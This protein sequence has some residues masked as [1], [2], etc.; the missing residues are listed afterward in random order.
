MRIIQIHSDGGVSKLYEK[1]DKVVIKNNVYVGLNHD[2]ILLRGTL[3]T[4]VECVVNYP[5]DFKGINRKPY[6]AEI[7]G[8]G[9]EKIYPWDIE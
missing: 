1:G 2:R 9:I 3:A 4:I 5:E 6:W 8:H 7:E